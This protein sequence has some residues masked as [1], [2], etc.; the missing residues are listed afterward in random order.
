MSLSLLIL[1]GLVLVMLALAASGTLGVFRPASSDP[2]PRTLLP[3]LGAVMAA[4]GLLGGSSSSGLPLPIGFEGGS[5]G[6]ELDALSCMFLLLVFLAALFG[7]WSADIE[8][9]AM[10]M[11]RLRLACIVLTLLAG[12]VFLLAVGGVLSILTIG[13]GPGAPGWP[14]RRVVSACCLVASCTLLA[15]A[16]TPAGALLPDAGFLLLRGET[17]AIEN[18]VGS[19]LLPLLVVGAIG[20]LLG[21]FPWSGWQRRLC[22]SAP[23]S[24]PALASLLG[25][26]LL[27][28]LLLDLAGTASP[29]G[30]GLLLVALGLI[31]SLSA[32]LAAFTA[33]RLRAACGGL[34]A[35]QNGLAVIAVGVCLLA[36]SDDLPL[37]ATSASDAVMLLIPVQLLAGLV[38]LRLARS[39]EDEA[40]TTLL[41]R[42][43][44]LAT[45]MPHAAPIV[46]ASVSI[47]AFMP[48]AGGF[49]GLWLLLQSTLAACRLGNMLLSVAGAVCTAG[50]VIAV[51]ISVTAW[52]RL[53][54]I[55]FLGRPR[56]PRGAAAQDIPRTLAIASVALLALPLLIGLVPGAWLRLMTQAARL[57]ASSGDADPPM[58]A[59][60]SPASDSLLWPLP[61]ALM[62]IALLAACHWT[63]RRLSVRPERREPVWEG[64]FAPPPAWLPFGDPLTQVGPA[65]LP[66]AVRAALTGSSPAIRLPF[67]AWFPRRPGRS[68]GPLLAGGRRASLGLDRALRQRGAASALFLLAATLALCGWWR[69]S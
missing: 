60:V 9:H 7:E 18:G 25:L 57:G 14:R 13:R 34:L 48:P 49:G 69:F 39:V 38:M 26:F 36:R 46:L 28:R 58:L 16:G 33:T 52:L 45:A 37:L 63:V 3:G 4:S 51:A 50:I 15:G 23:A 40:G 21:L 20:P 65:A 47:L 22:V 62:S 61:L 11:H 31:T 66:G 55:V 56:T 35:L 29:G 12:D 27:L 19:V 6:L 42:L 2:I 67:A 8:R 32:A 54:A 64:G 53:A 68:L 43:G 1:V 41:G 24:V 30:W 59:L 44:G 17:G 10:P 5:G